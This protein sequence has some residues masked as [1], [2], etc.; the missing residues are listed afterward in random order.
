M[1]NLH[2]NV[3]MNRSQLHCIHG[4]LPI[5]YQIT[6]DYYETLYHILNTRILI[7]IASLHSFVS[8]IMNA[9]SLGHISIWLRKYAIVSSFWIV[10]EKNRI[11]CTKK[12][13]FCFRKKVDTM[14]VDNGNNKSQRKWPLLKMIQFCFIDKNEIF[15]GRCLSAVH[16]WF[17]SRL[18][19]LYPMLIT[20][21]QWRVHT[22]LVL[23]FFCC[24]GWICAGWM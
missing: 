12:P 5:K 20:R 14:D 3:M 17:F 19:A 11:V 21:I 24:F 13:K 15:A 22:K 9:S 23:I 16:F 4:S 8:Y 6:N 18:N 1:S 10:Y 7:R 2:E